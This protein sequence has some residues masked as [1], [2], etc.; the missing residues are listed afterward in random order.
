MRAP[1]SAP[2]RFLAPVMAILLAC[3]GCSTTKEVYRKEA[4]QTDT[5]FSARIAGRSKAVCWSVKRALLSQGYM[6]DNSADSVT[7]TGVKEF[8]TD[9]DT[10]VELRMQ[11]SCA[12]NGDGTSTVF[13]T[14]I[15]EI[16]KVQTVK[17]SISAGVAI[18]TIT[19]PVGSE[20]VMQVLNRKTI[21]DPKFYRRFY[22]LVSDY[23]AGYGAPR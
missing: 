20:K 4:F 18:A 2:P 11:T 16:G 6:L 13:A 14:A 19:V 9:S 21:E 17:Q 10:N 22:R 8:Q 12:D 1:A 3:G 7:L 5:P 23:A 15:R